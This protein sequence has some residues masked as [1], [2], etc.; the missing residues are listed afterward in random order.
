MWTVMA[1][2][3]VSDIRDLNLVESWLLPRF[4]N[5]NQSVSPLW[6]WCNWCTN[7]WTVYIILGKCRGFSWD[8]RCI[9]MN[10][11]RAI[12]HVINYKNGR[13]LHWKHSPQWSH[14]LKN[15]SFV[16]I[17]LWGTSIMSWANRNFKLTWVESL[18]T[19][20]K[21]MVRAFTY[22]TVKYLI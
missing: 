11:H 1:C 21:M 13:Y 10:H 18:W 14:F 6:N 16:N 15:A 4:P 9:D 3:Y 20:K 7:T 8:M 5:F 2:D 12:H 22:S 19:F 17:S